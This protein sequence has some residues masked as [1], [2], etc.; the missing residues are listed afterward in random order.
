MDRIKRG[1][2]GAALAF[3]MGLSALAVSGAN[4]DGLQAAGCGNER[5]QLCAKATICSGWW[6]FKTCVETYHYYPDF[7]LD[8]P[9]GDELGGGGGF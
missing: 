6:I 4:P 5:G 2:R 7:N 1:V 9:G 3:G 8:G